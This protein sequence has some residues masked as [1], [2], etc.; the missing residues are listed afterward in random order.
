MLKHRQVEAAFPARSSS[1][2]QY[3]DCGGHSQD[4]STCGQSARERFGIRDALEILFERSGGRLV[5]TGDAMALYREIDRSVVGL[6]RI[7]GLARDLRKT[8]RFSA[9][10]GTAG[11][12]NG[13]LPAFAAGFLT[14]HR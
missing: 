10:R 4:H 14:G 5:A 8:R 11:L 3:R 13:F 12:A 1:A 9:H 7:A 6:E 2:V